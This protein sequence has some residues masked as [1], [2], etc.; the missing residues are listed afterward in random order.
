MASRPWR[1]GNAPD[2]VGVS[3][4]VEEMKGV[5][6][7][8]LVSRRSQVLWA[9]GALLFS[10]RGFFLLGHFLFTLLQRSFSS[11][12]HPSSLWSVVIFFSLHLGL[13]AWR[14]LLLNRCRSL[15]NFAFAARLRL[16][17][18]RLLFRFD[19]QLADT[20]SSFFSSPFLRPFV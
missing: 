10:S 15:F 13:Q 17:W 4:M 12:F 2:R 19:I 11:S 9:K 6:S 16:I 3:S 18:H 14:R 20:T 5:V 1:L 8:A 7:L